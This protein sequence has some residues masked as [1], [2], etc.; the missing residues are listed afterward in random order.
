MARIR[1]GIRSLLKS[2]L[3]SLLVVLSLGLGIG[4]NT[5]VFS[6]TRQVLLN[7]LPV[8]APQELVLVNSPGEFKSGSSSTNQAGGMD[9]IFS[10]P[11]FRALEKQP[12]G[13]EGLAG[14][15]RRTGNLAVGN[16]TVEGSIIAVSG[17]YFSMLG[18][19]PLIGRAITPSDDAAANPIAVLGYNYWQNRLSGRPDALNQPIT[20]NGIPFTIVGIAP[21][22]FNGVTL[23]DVP[24]IYVSITQLWPLFPGWSGTERYDAYWVYLVGRLK[25]GVTLQQ[26]D[27]AL[28]G[29]Y[30]GLIE[31]QTGVLRFRNPQQKER[32]AKS[33]LRLIDGRQGNSYVRDSNRTAITILF[34]ATALVLAIA[35]ANAANLLLARS[36][37]RRRE[38]AIRVALGASRGEVISQMLTEA[39]LVSAAG[40]VAGLAI[41]PMSLKLLLAEMAG[42]AP[43]YFASARL[44][45]PAL[46]FC[47]GL[48]M[49]IGLVFGLYPAWE[50]ARTSLAGTLK[51]EAGQSSSTRG[52]ARV[53]RVLVC[54]QVMISA[55]L[56]IPTGM[57]LR[58]LVNVLRVDLGLNTENVVGFSLSPRL[59]QYSFEACGT[60]FDR[61]E[62]ELAA[63]PGIQS[64]MASMVPLIGNSSWGTNVYVEGDTTHPDGVN[65]KYSELGPRFFGKMGIPL[66]AGREF[67]DSDTAAAPKVAVVNEEFVKQLFGGRNPIG[68]HFARDSKLKGAPDIEI[69]GLVKNSHYRAVRQEPIPVFYTPWRQDNRVSYMNFYVRSALPAGQTIQEIRQLMSSLDRNLP[70]TE[71]RTLDETVRWNI[72]DDRLILKLAIVFAGLATVLA[73]LGLYGVMAHSVTRRTREIGIR[74][75]LGARPGRIRSMVMREL[76]WILGLGLAGGIPGALA[77]SR[78]TR[79]QLYGVKANDAAIVIAASVVLALTAALAGYLPARRAAKVNPVEALRYE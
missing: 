43:N 75:A 35:M 69:V 14:F 67:S 65:A 25:R 8:K 63:L 9:F 45:W 26:A 19:D 73:M 58:S 40:G 51:D 77:L 27:A 15:V 13:L 21:K 59:N 31:R 72:R 50:A 17:S 38:L 16:Q 42:D 70:A 76:L 79:N 47:L 18:V 61:V 46:L 34:V 64:S 52:V 33:R 41:A 71:M 23:G 2:P 28:N 12:A 4:A 3:V 57:F 5:A 62:R 7:T 37:G 11:V 24:D 54:A 56:L 48:A 74:L 6:L 44:D 20:V 66:I 49:A 1:Y 39:L 60:L 55:I 78:F 68:R 32:F 36:A 30:A 29:V 10:Y 53:R 22:G